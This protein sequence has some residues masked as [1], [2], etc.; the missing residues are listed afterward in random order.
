MKET[1][2]F[3]VEREGGLDDGGFSSAS[4]R[5]RIREQLNADIE[6]FLSGGGRIIRVDD[7]VRADPPRPPDTRYGSQPI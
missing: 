2:D 6:A 7:S 4:G 1:D 3:P 5:S